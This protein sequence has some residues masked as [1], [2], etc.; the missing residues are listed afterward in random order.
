MATVIPRPSKP[1]CTGKVKLL[2]DCRTPAPVRSRTVIGS[3]ERR[4][5]ALD[6]VRVHRRIV[7]AARG[8]RDVHVLSVRRDAR[9]GTRLLRPVRRVQIVVVHGAARGVR[10][11]PE[12][13]QTAAARRRDLHRTARQLAESA[14]RIVVV[15]GLQRVDDVQTA[16]HDAA[17]IAA[18][19]PRRGDAHAGA[20][21]LRPRG[22]RVVPDAGAVRSAGLIRDDVHR[23]VQGDRDVA[24]AA[25]ELRPRRAVVAVDA[26]GGVDGPQRAVRCDREP[27]RGA[28]NVGPRA[29]DVVVDVMVRA[30]PERRERPQRAVR[31]RRDEDGCTAELGPPE[32]RDV[33]LRLARA[34]RRA[35]QQR[36]A[37]HRRC[38]DARR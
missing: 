15:D 14:R 2:H 13:E 30:V 19:V 38:R 22:A 32:H 36:R 35:G 27:G 10:G 28:W 9:A 34:H 31:A 37:R 16:R 20:D 18:R 23:V 4:S 25:G 12:R 33:A 29:A 24:R 1:L 11:E 3:G 5:V 7:D 21:D 6:V 8:S 26:A 17:R